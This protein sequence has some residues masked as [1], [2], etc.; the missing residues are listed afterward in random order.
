MIL[1]TKLLLAHLIG[2]F[3]LQPTSWVKAKEEKKLKAWQL[4]LHALIHGLLAL[5]V[6]WDWQ[7]WNWALFI[8]GI[9]L[10]IDASKV[11]FQ[12]DSTKRLFFFV[13]QLFHLV[14]IYLIVIYSQNLD[15]P[16]AAVTNE[17]NILLLTLVLLLTQPTS[18]AIR[19]FISKW[20]PHTGDDDAESLQSAGKYIGIIERLFVF[21]FVLAAQWEAIGFLIAAKSIFRFGDLKEAKDRKLTE[22]ILIGTLVS[23]GIAILTGL[24][25]LRAT[26]SLTSQ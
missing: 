2:D 4:Y 14:S 6:V 19:V 20:T 7:F 21:A 25:Y 26:T 12:R 16:I 24:I 11:I 13:D 10:V 9:H 3:L 15:F 22:Y 1:I 8:A 17:K 5:L 18:I 23:F